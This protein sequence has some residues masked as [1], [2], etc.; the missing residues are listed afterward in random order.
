MKFEILQIVSPSEDVKFS[1]VRGTL[2][3]E[4]QYADSE[5]KI[6]LILCPPFEN[7]TTR[8]TILIMEL[9]ELHTYM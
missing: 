8:T 9:F 4:I 5:A 3:K 6:F 7:S 1:N 2:F